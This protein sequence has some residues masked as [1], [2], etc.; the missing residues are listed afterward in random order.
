MAKIVSALNILKCNLFRL[1]YPN[2]SCF[3]QCLVEFAKPYF[4]RASVAC[5]PTCSRSNIPINVSTRQRR[6]NFSTWRANVPS[7]RPSNFSIS[8]AKRRANFQ[9]FFKRIILF[10]YL[11]Y[12][13]VRYFFMFVYFKYISNIYFYLNIFFIYL[14]LY[15]M[16]KKAYLE[17]CKSWTS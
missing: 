12:L 16:C 17:K 7:K 2:Y 9:L 10:I 13:C 14:T 4:M 15:A 11:I 8:P 5:V 1:S 3:L 6:T